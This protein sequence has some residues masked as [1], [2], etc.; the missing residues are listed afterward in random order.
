[1]NDQAAARLTRFSRAGDVLETERLEFVTEEIAPGVVLTHRP[2]VP[3]G[4]G[5]FSTTYT[6][7]GGSMG[8]IVGSPVPLMAPLFRIGA[9]GVIADTM[10][11]EKIR[12]SSSEALQVLGQRLPVPQ[13]PDDR[14]LRVI[15][16]R[17]VLS[18]DRTIPSAPNG[19]VTLTRI[20][21]GGDTLSEWALGYAPQAWSAESIDA[22][23]AGPL[24][25]WSNRVG[26]DADT[27]IAAAALREALALP[28]YQAPVSAARLASDCVVWLERESDPSR[29]RRVALVGVDGNPLG[30]L[31][32]PRGVEVLWSSGSTVWA[33]LTEEL[34]VPWL[35]RYRLTR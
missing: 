22:L 4:S 19:S 17:G 32:L 27:S 23:M 11:L 6:I 35:V 8:A 10:V 9:D 13:A 7:G 1:V 26:A 30:V 25:I 16:A 12:G 14:P 31:A 24:R 20:G 34:D 3:L 29:Q 21:L 33:S 28:P 2:A 15:D 18:V 5:Q